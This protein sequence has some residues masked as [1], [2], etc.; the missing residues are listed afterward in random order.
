MIFASFRT[1]G[2]SDSNSSRSVIWSCVFYSGA[3]IYAALPEPAAGTSPGTS[4]VHSGIP[5]V[6]DVYP[7]DQFALEQPDER[8]FAR[9]PPPMSLERRERHPPLEQRRHDGPRVRG[10]LGEHPPRPRQHQK[11][12]AYPSRFR[13]FRRRLARRVSRSASKARV[14]ELNATAMAVIVVQHFEPQ[15]LGQERVDSL[16]WVEPAQ[17]RNERREDSPT[18]TTMVPDYRALRATSLTRTCHDLPAFCVVTV[19]QG[20]QLRSRRMAAISRGFRR[21]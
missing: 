7:S 10:V 1:G 15:H 9:H 3:P 20:D 18:D 17:H 2:R 14:R 13:P 12:I 16:D 6:G 21:P 8:P 19:L 5:P 4:R 11:L